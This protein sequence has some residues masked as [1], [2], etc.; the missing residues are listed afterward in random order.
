MPGLIELDPAASPCSLVGSGELRGARSAPPGAAAGNGF[1]LF[2][3]LR[4]LCIRPG[5]SKQIGEALYSCG[6]SPVLSEKP[7][8]AWTPTSSLQG[9]IHGVLWKK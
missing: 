8:E 5:R 9:R 1:G 2:G 7:P 4:C 3:L 6:D